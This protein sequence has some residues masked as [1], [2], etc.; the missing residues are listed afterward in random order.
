MSKRKLTYEVNETNNTAYLTKK[1]KLITQ[2]NNIHDIP[3]FDEFKKTYDD[4]QYIPRQLLFMIEKLIQPSIKY[5]ERS[6][7]AHI[8]TK[9]NDDASPPDPDDDV[10]EYD[11]QFYP[12]TDIVQIT[13][14]YIVSNENTDLQNMIFFIL[15]LYNRITR[16]NYLN[17]GKEQTETQAQ[18]TDD[19]Y[20]RLYAR[21]VTN[22]DANVQLHR[23]KKSVALERLKI[24]DKIH[25]DK[26]KELLTRLITTNETNQIR[27]D[28]QQ[29]E[30]AKL[31]VSYYQLYH[32]YNR[33]L[34]A[35]I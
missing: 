33:I 9:N 6:A 16:H 5:N 14:E 11:L 3:S 15:F 32:H 18:Y 30:F 8:E 4:T 27:I 25:S 35:D 26:Y 1:K 17:S 10:N 23:D 12:N 21:L 7:R 28:R 20:N 31:R 2:A 19:E 29:E 24:E 22:F 34:N 13:E